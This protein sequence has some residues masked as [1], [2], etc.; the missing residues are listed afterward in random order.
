M[1]CLL[2]MS[3]EHLQTKM[4]TFFKLTAQQLK[5]SKK[6]TSR[7]PQKLCNQTCKKFTCTLI[8]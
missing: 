5:E 1:D 2:I 4:F 7:Y 6:H 8:I 3:K